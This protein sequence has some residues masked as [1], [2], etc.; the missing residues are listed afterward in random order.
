MIGEKVGYNFCLYYYQTYT[1]WLQVRKCIITMFNNYIIQYY[2]KQIV[3]FISIYR[4]FNFF[5]DFIYDVLN[6]N[7]KKFKSWLIKPHR[8]FSS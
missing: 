1:I 5:W 8:L 2:S 6:V 7:A 4:I 3:Y